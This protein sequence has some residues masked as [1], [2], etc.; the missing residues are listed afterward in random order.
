MKGP[1]GDHGVEAAASKKPPRKSGYKRVTSVMSSMKKYMVKKV[2]GTGEVKIDQKKN[3]A[4][5]QNIPYEEAG[6]VS[7]QEA[8]AAGV[9]TSASKQ[10]NMRKFA[11]FEDQL[12]QIRM[13]EEYLQNNPD[14]A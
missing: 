7:V 6:E 5:A 4:P 13:S 1:R 9:P 11:S 8:E 2:Y 3:L 14:V 10:E 12:K